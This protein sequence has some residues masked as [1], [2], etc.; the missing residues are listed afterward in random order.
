MGKKKKS[1]R[2]RWT[3]C[4][5]NQHRGKH[6]P[7]LVSQICIFLAKH[8]RILLSINWPRICPRVLNCFTFQHARYCTLAHSLARGNC[9]F[10]SKLLIPSCNVLV[11]WP[12]VIVSKIPSAPPTLDFRKTIGAVLLHLGFPARGNCSKLPTT[13]LA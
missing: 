3:F 4:M 7:N 9:T 5:R 13:V 8:K 6:F 11:L 2:A 10:L 12:E 1:M